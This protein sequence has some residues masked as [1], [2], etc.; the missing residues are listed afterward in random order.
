MVHTTLHYIPLS[1]SAHFGSILQGVSYLT[2]RFSAQQLAVNTCPTVL[3]KRGLVI[4]ALFSRL[5]EDHCD[6]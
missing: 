1:V 2:V 5:R 4:Y 6:E 3:V